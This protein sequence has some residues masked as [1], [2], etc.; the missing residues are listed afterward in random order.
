MQPVIVRPRGPRML[1]A[2]GRDEPER[3]AQPAPAGVR[4]RDHGRADRGRD[5]VGLPVDG[6]DV[7]GVHPHGRE[8][9]VG[10]DAGDACRSPGGRRRS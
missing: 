6:L 7:A 10:V 8:V 4:E 2:R 5:D 1:A 3:R 9:E